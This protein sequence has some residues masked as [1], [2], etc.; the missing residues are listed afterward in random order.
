MAIMT[1]AKFDFN[2]LMLTLTFGIWASEPPPGPG[3][4]LKRPGLIG[5]NRSFYTQASTILTLHPP[6][7]CLILLA[8]K[9]SYTNDIIILLNFL[10]TG[11]HSYQIT[12]GLSLLLLTIHV[13]PTHFY[14]MLSFWQYI[15]G[16]KNNIRTAVRRNLEEVLEVKTF[17]KMSIGIK[18]KV[19]N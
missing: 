11:L 6:P 13:P 10:F 1:R 19:P 3:E 12:P 17:L 4:R 14:V 7:Q 18:S 8:C 15:E 5:L 9:F 2:W 16:L